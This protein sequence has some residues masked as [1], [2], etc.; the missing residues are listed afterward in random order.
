M[1]A[2][3]CVCKCVCMKYVGQDF[4]LETLRQNLELQPVGKFLLLQKNLRFFISR[5][6]A[7]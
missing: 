2:H 6:S 4:T 5:P 7:D 3:M 1:C